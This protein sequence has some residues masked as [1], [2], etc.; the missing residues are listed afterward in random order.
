MPLQDAIILLERFLDYISGMIWIVVMLEIPIV[1]ML[2]L[3]CRFLDVFIKNLDV[4]LL[5]RDF[6]DPDGVLCAP[7]RGVFP[8]QDVCMIT[9]HDAYITYMICVWRKKGE[10]H[11]PTSTV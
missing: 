5:S 8:Q 10:A 3:L 11:D 2:E 4:I 1:A 9:L 6:L 7:E